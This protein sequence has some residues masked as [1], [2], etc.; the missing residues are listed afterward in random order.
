MRS[1]MNV[2]LVE[3]SQIIQRRCYELWLAMEEVEAGGP[4]A[5]NVRKGLSQV[6]LELNINHEF[7]MKNASLWDGGNLFDAELGAA[8]GNGMAAR[9]RKECQVGNDRDAE[10]ERPRWSISPIGPTGQ[11]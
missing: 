7:V 8:E 6:Y 4:V 3:S 10:N 1:S 11:N 2:D 5:A 9:V